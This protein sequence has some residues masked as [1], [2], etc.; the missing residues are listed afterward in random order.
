MIKDNSYWISNCLD[1]PKNKKHNIND[2]VEEDWENTDQSVWLVI[3][4]FKTANSSKP[5][6]KIVEKINFRVMRSRLGIL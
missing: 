2:V 5:V 4:T 6:T 1:D 3:K